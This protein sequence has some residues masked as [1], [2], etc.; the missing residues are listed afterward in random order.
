MHKNKLL[1]FGQ[2]QRQRQRVGT[3]FVQ[4]VAMQNDLGAKTARALSMRSQ[5]QFFR[6]PS[7]AA[8]MIKAAASA[9]LQLRA[10]PVTCIK[11]TVDASGVR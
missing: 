6:V 7:K 3:G 2:R 10:R 1:L 5:A 11:S 9:T 8:P 4:R